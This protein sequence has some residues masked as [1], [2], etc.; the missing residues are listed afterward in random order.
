[1]TPRNS[2]ERSETL[3]FEPARFY[4]KVHAGDKLA[5]AICEGAVAIAPVGD[6][7][8]EKGLLGAGFLADIM[9]GKYRDGLPLYRQR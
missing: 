7:V 1:V 9:V 6:K 4:V 5:C 8:I 2:Y 3:E